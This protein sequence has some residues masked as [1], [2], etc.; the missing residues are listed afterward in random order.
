MRFKSI[1]LETLRDLYLNELRDLFNAEKQLVRGLPQM[2]EAAKSHEL[3]EAFVNHLNETKGQVGRLER[4]FDALGEK[5][6]GETCE[7]MKGLL[8]EAE[9]FIEAVGNHDVIDAGLIAAAQRVEHY[10]MAGYGTA[11]ALA[12]RLGAANDAELLQQTLDEEKA[13]DQT[14]TR[15]AESGVNELAAHAVG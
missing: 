7:A 9:M 4:I 15:I 1:N 11:R 5:P 14:L 3:K 6:T 2:V 12:L 13:A 10:E 8:E